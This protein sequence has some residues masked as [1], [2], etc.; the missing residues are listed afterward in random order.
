MADGA[1]TRLAKRRVQ[2]LPP[3]SPARRL[4]DAGLLGL[5]LLI[6]ALAFNRFLV[7]HHIACGGVVGLSGVV[8]T[9]W[10]ADPAVVQ[11]VINLGILA[12]GWGL[13]GRGVALRALAASLLLPA[14][15]VLTRGPAWAD[16]PLLA[17]IAGGAGVG[18][19]LG[20]ALRSG[21]TTGGFSLLARMLDRR[22]GWGVATCLAGLDGV[23]V[24]AAGLAA[25]SPQAAVLALL[26][27]FATTRAVDLANAG[28]SR[29]KALWIVSNR[30]AELRELI[31]HQ[32]DLGCTVVP[33]RGGFSDQP[34]DL[35]MV[36]V[37]PGD[38]WRVK[39]AVAAA[40]PAAFTIVADTHEVMGHGF[41]H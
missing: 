11:V 8:R 40:D 37:A 19:G 31:L 1:T 4:A 28:L 27:V 33:A 21:W 39:Q 25:G 20:L 17:A 18:L 2:R 10:E 9:A 3:G 7:P 36:V 15:V 5:G 29:A 35:L 6:L 26:A 41:H 16:E 38:L 22:F 23:V 32:L 34:C 30:S 24:V 12:A 14:A 13:L